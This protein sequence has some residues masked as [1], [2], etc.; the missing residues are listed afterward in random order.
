VT[1]K[2]TDGGDK[3]EPFMGLGLA[4]SNHSNS[5]T[6]VGFN[7]YYIDPNPDTQT[8]IASWH[9]GVLV[10]N[11][12]YPTMEK[13]METKAKENDDVAGIDSHKVASS[14]GVNNDS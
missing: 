7:P 9:E 13:Y 3:P 2:S 5:S 11:T 10:F 4:S 6:S 8:R 1:K 14:R 12:S